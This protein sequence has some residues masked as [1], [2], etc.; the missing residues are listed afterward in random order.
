MGLFSQGIKS[1]L[2]EYCEDMYKCSEDMEE[3]L[4]VEL[5]EDLKIREP[6]REEVEFAIKDLKVGKSPGC[7]LVTS[8]MIKASGEQGLDV[9]HHLCK[10]ICHQGKW[11]QEWKKSIFIPIP[12]KGDLKECTNYHTIYLINHASKIILKTIQRRLETKFEEEVSATQAGFRKGS[13]TRD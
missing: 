11:P 9:Y 1:R 7:D 2:K 13:G 6:M 8:K 3:E 10:K 4:E 5:T 12:K